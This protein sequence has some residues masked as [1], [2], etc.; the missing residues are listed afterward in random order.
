MKTPIIFFSFSQIFCDCLRCLQAMA[1]KACSSFESRCLLFE[2]S[3]RDNFDKTVDKFDVKALLAVLLMLPC[4]VLAQENPQVHIGGALRF[5]YN[6]STYDK[7]QQIRGGDINY[8]MFAISPKVSYKDLYVDIEYR[9]YEHQYGGGM[10]RFGYVGYDISPT[11]HIHFGLTKVPFGLEAYNSHSYFL[12]MSYYL[13]LEDDYDLGIKYMRETDHFDYQ[14]AFFKN[15]DYGSFVN[16]QESMSRY[17][18]DVGGLNRE[19]NQLN[20]KL[21]YKPGQ[22]TKG[23]LGISAQYGGLLNTQTEKM[24]SHYAV[25]GHYK[26]NYKHFDVK[27]QIAHYIYDP[28]NNHTVSDDIIQLVAYNATYNVASKATLYSLALGYG[29]EVNK[30]ILSNVLIYDDFAYLDKNVQSFDYSA[31]NTLGVL[32]VLGKIYTYVECIFA[33][34][35]PWFGGDWQQSFATGTI[36]ARWETKLNINVGYYF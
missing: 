29:I 6:I 25:A 8:D 27:A 21:E 15:S 24:G 35:H 10:L 14:L 17:S 4:T 16:G 2:N 7:L 1:R 3:C 19:T 11:S 36:D 34:N 23:K 20:I 30:K 33:K 22:K 12:G 13:G 9:L 5:N 26:L 18:Y 32:L 28:E 31:S